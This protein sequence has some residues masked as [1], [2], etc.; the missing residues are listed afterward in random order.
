VNKDRPDWWRENHHLREELNLP[1]YR[2]PRFA[3]GI[4]THAITDEIETNHDCQ[5]QFIGVDTRYPDDWEVW[6][7]GEAAFEICRYR[8]DHGNT[9]YE[10]S[11]EEFRAAIETQLSR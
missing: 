6:I 5:L 2:P 4:Y 3:D 1:E 11:S 8:D 7:N 10:I 9:V